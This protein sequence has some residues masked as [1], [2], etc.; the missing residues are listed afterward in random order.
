MDPAVDPH[1]HLGSSHHELSLLALF[2]LCF[3]PIDFLSKMALCRF[4]VNL[5]FFGFGPS[6]REVLGP[7]YD[8]YPIGLLYFIGLYTLI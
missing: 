5:L 2:F 7:I 3:E 4:C 8:S 6:S 1:L